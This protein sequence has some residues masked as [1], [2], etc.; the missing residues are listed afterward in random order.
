MLVLGTLPATSRAVLESVRDFSRGLTVPRKLA[1]RSNTPHPSSNDLE[2]SLQPLFERAG[3]VHHLDVTR[4][5][6]FGRY[7]IDFFHSELGIAIEVMGYRADDEVFKDLLKFHVHPATRVGVLWAPRWKWISG[8]RSDANHHAIRKA[9]A[10]A[11]G[12]L[13]VE[14]L[15]AVTYDFVSTESGWCL[16]YVDEVP[17]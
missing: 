16:S 10:F 2:R 12:G 8:V 15:V 14:A 1:S 7:E 17:G 13:N 6:I 3:F 4:N 11:N 5:E 9:L